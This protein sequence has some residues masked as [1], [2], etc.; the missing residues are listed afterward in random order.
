VVGFTAPDQYAKTLT[1]SAENEVVFL[2]IDEVGNWRITG[3]TAYSS[4]PF[5]APLLVETGEGVAAGHHVPFLWTDDLRS[6]MPAVAGSS[7]AGPAK[8]KLLTSR[9]LAAFSFPPT[10]K[11]ETSRTRF[12]TRAS[13]ERAAED[14]E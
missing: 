4:I 6:V 9:H 3:G 11:R 12:R 13:S 5:R 10:K 8:S 7:T 1:L 14:T 2:T